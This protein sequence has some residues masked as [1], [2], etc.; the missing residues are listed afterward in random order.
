[1][2]AASAS[3]NRPAKPRKPSSPVKKELSTRALVIIASISSAVLSSALALGVQYYGTLWQ[4]ERAERVKEVS[5]FVE[6]AQQF[7]KLVTNFMGP[8]LQGRD[9]AAER[10]AL[11]ENLQ[12]QHQLIETAKTNLSAEE[13]RRATLYQNEL[14]RVSEEL[15][16]HLA[17]P[18]A[19]ALAQAIADTKAANV[20]VVYDLRERAGLP[21]VVSDKEACSL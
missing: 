1:M 5:A 12:T 2:T 16:R 4:D 18:Q 13:S 20:C 11:R 7:D 21:T 19:Q 14:V 17:A 3:T 15:D 9:D 8:F 6:S 10:K